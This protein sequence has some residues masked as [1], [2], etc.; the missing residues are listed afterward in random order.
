MRPYLLPCLA[1]ATAAPMG[2]T[3]RAIAQDLFTPAPQLWVTASP[4]FW[5]VLRIYR[6]ADMDGD[7]YAEYAVHGGTDSGLPS[8][9]TVR[10][11][12]G[13]SPTIRREWVGQ[14]QQM[15]GCPFANPGGELYGKYGAALDLNGDGLRQEAV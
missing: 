10:V 13:R 7:G 2:L 15:L 8:P 14:P 9:G 6:L 1:A 3:P 5:P 4:S 11:Y 12:D